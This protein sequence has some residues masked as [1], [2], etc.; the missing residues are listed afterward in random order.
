MAEYKVAQLIFPSDNKAFDGGKSWSKNLLGVA[1]TGFV[2]QLGIHAMPGTKVYIG[3]MLSGDLEEN[4]PHIVIGPSGVFQANVD[5][6]YLL[7]DVRL[8][9]QSYDN[10]VAAGQQIIFDFVGTYAPGGSTDKVVV[11]NGG[12]VTGYV[13]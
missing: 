12:G 1:Q 11:Y 10:A 2:R 5:E 7:M 3:P 6:G 8:Q 13:E 9:K 4:M